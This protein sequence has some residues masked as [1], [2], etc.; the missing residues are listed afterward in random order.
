MVAF[1]FNKL[2]VLVCSGKGERERER[3]RK[4]GGRQTRAD[5]NSFHSFLM[6]EI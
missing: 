4:E 5:A 6:R 3:E 2:K 1:T